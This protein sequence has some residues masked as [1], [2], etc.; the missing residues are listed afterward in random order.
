MGGVNEEE[1]IK[2]QTLFVI[3][4]GTE[5]TNINGEVTWKY[6]D[7]VKK[8]PVMDII[9]NKQTVSWT[10]HYKLKSPCVVFAFSLMSLDTT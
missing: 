1:F 7:E 8:I 9:N 5:Q 10:Q 6:T 2:C 4:G 3:G